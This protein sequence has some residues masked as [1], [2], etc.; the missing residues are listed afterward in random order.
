MGEE[1]VGAEQAR[2]LGWALE[3]A[4]ISCHQLWWRYFS[5][6]GQAGEYELDAYLHHALHLPRLQR[7]LLAQAANELITDLPDE[8]FLPRAPYTDELTPPQGPY[9]I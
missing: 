8:A 4:Q 9:P 3:C 6:G 7:D 5:F 2:L 1:I